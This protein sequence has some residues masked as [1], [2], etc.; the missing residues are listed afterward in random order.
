MCQAAW[1]ASHTKNSYLMAFHK[2]IAFRRGAQKATMALAHHLIAIVYNVLARGE[3][4]VELGADFY[5]RQNKPKVVSRLVGRL[6]RLGYAVELKPLIEQT[7]ELATGQFS[8]AAD[9]GKERR[10]NQDNLSPLTRVTPKRK[11]G[12]PCKCAVKGIGCKHGRAS[13]TGI[14]G[15]ETT[16]PFSMLKPEGANVLTPVE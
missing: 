2:R 8:V 15:S 13:A 10:H 6:A 12:R 4:Y 1:A 7:G 14:W 9:P 11:P 3:E 5:D 16:P